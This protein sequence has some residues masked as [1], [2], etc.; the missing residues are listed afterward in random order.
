ME[1]D[2]IVGKDK[3]KTQILRKEWDTNEQYRG[4]GTGWRWE[5]WK[6]VGVELREPRGLTGVK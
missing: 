4:R 1:K 5:R 3:Q 2:I 6:G